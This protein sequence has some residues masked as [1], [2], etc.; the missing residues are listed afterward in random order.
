MNSFAPLAHSAKLV[1]EK[2]PAI[3]L[4]TVEHDNAGMKNSVVTL[5]IRES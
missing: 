3:L 2:R 5:L 4:Y 1:D